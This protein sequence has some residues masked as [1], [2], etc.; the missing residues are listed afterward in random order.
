MRFNAF[1]LLL[2]LGTFNKKF[3]TLCIAQV[4]DLTSQLLPDKPMLL[5]Y[6]GHQVHSQGSI[7]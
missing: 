5:I 1:Y 4:I 3:Y 2:V 7:V 6:H